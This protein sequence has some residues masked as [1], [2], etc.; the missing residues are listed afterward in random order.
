MQV[1]TASAAGEVKELMA[2]KR[3]LLT[4]IKRA[5]RSLVKSR[6]EKNKINEELKRIKARFATMTTDE[7]RAAVATELDA[8]STDDIFPKRM[9]RDFDRLDRQGPKQD[10]RQIVDLTGA[11]ATDDGSSTRIHNEGDGD[12]VVVATAPATDEDSDTLPDLD[13]SEE[14]SQDDEEVI[15]FSDE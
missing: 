3:R 10:E 12:V 8:I 15:D 6:I 7:A 13:I 14:E 1:E 2:K 9:E 11:D 4:K 5:K